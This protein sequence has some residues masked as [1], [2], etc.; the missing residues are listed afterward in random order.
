M[1]GCPLL[2]ASAATAY[3]CFASLSLLSPSS[4]LSIYPKYLSLSVPESPAV[5]VKPLPPSF[6]LS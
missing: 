5:H 2:P 1:I 6:Y 3:S 4:F